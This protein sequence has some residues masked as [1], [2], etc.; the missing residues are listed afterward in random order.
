MNVAVCIDKEGGMMFLGRRQSMDRV[1]REKLLSLTD[2][3]V[4]LNEF[5]AD[6]FFDKSRL[7]VSEDFLN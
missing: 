3:N 2:G 4:F 6:M 5:S 7:V 1:Q